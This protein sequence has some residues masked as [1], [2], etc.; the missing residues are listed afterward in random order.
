MNR[1]P[2]DRSLDESVLTGAPIPMVTEALAR[3]WWA[4]VLRGAAAIVF[5]GLA[6][7]L[8]GA[9]LAALIFLFGAYAL[10]DGLFNV[11]AALSGRTHA[12]S[13][14][15]LLVAGLT[16]IAAGVVT[17]LMPGVTA[18]ALLYV[19]AAWAVVRGILEIAAAV[20]LRQV[21]ADEWWLGLAGALSIV[22][23]ILVMV[24]PGAGA[25]AL[26]L[27][28]GAYAVLLGVFLVALGLRL[29]G[30][31]AGDRAATTRRAA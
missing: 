2:D 6:L 1:S 10:V 27:W 25:L 19:I 20:R 30:W 23:G 4:I 5:G 18:L 16:S 29:R 9:T 11:V 24:A 7:A 28:I 21:I 26:V 13:W 15:A 8:P 22:F 12:R 3:G 31:R 14:S 17:F